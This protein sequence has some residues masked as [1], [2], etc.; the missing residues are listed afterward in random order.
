MPFDPLYMLVMA[1]GMV[2]AGVTSWYVKSTFA[3][4]SKQDVASGITG[5]QAARMIL[6]RN[7]IHD[8]EVVQSQGFLT[9]LYH[10]VKKVI[11]LSPDVYQ[12]ATVAAIGVAAHEAGHAVQHATGFVFV[13][14]RNTLVPIAQ[15]STNFAWIL[16]MI[17]LAIQAMGVAQIGVLLFATVVAYQ[18]V[19]LPV[20]LDASRRALACVT[21]YGILT[22]E[23]HG[24]AYKVLRAAA[25]TYLAAAITAALQLLYFMLRT[26]MLGGGNRRD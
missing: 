2:L 16:I 15:I 10:P 13:H 8:V 6:E 20:E 24:A 25:F 4:Y 1:I 17:G 7:G 11:Q 14:L 3:R 19:T 22:R 18:V 23:E 9:D 12:R 21:Q 26:G 5:A